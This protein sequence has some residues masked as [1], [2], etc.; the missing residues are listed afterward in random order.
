MAG[1]AD[2]S[3]NSG[4]QLPGGVAGD[5]RDRA[6]GCDDRTDSALHRLSDHLSHAGA[7]PAGAERGAFETG[8]DLHTWLSHRRLFE[9]PGWLAGA[10]AFGNCVAAV[11]VGCSIK[12]LVP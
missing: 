8:V 2:Y 11:G 3:R 5:G 10:D 12:L 9:C 1:G 4:S 6:G 7:V